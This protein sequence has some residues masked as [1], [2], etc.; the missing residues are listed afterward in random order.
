MRYAITSEVLFSHDVIEVLAGDLSSICRCPLQHF[1]QLR[2]V[3][4]FSQ[5]LGNSSDVIDVDGASSVVVKKV[6]DSADSILIVKIVTL[7]SLSPSLEVMASRNS[8]KSMSRPPLSRSAI[9]W[10]MV[11]FFDSKPK[12]CIA[13]FNSLR[14]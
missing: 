10:K 11:G 2:Y 4:R 5:F 7:V 12:L 9:M 6:E 14:M 8:S 13:D 1:L 3:H